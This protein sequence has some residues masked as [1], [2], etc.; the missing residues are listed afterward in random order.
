MLKSVKKQLKESAGI[1]CMADSKCLLGSENPYLLL[2][3]VKGLVDF[4]Q[5]TPLLQ[6]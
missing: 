3:G 5:D 1:S 6:Y 4:F 2:V